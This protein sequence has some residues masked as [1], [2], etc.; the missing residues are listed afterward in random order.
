MG[1][2]ARQY[3]DKRRDGHEDQRRDHIMG[4]LGNRGAVIVAYVVISFYIRYFGVMLS[5]GG[6][7]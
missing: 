3:F 2:M 7:H 4:N 1:R 6:I 5:A